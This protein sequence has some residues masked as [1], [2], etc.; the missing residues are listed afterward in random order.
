[1]SAQSLPPDIVSVF[2]Y[3]PRAHRAECSC[4]HES[5]ARRRKTRAIV[6]AVLH[7][8][9]TGCIENWPLVHASDRP[10]EHRRRGGLRLAAASLAAASAIVGAAIGLSVPARA[11]AVDDYAAIHQEHIC[12]EI[13]A[14]PYFG[15]VRLLV[16]EI[17]ADTGSYEFAGAVLGTVVR[18]Y[19]PWN[20]GTFQRWIAVEIPAHTKNA[21]V[22]L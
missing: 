18:D 11:D 14:R 20:R 8:A 4:G 13:A 1:M 10:I 15:T 16:E 2:T 12:T 5:K 22:V 9:N 19:C 3:G 21:E 7:A 17:A 6:D